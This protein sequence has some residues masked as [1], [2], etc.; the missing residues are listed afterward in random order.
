MK[1]LHWNGVE[2]WDKSRWGLIIGANPKRPAE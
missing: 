2:T 1:V